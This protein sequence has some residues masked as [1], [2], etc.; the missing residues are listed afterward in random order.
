MSKFIIQLNRPETFTLN[1]AQ[2][3][4]FVLNLVQKQGPIGPEGPAGSGGGGSLTVQE[5]DGNPSGNAS[6]LIF[7]NGTVSIDGTT[8]TITGLQGAS[9][10]ETFETVSQNLKA[11]QS[12]NNYTDNRLTSIIYTVPSMGAIQKTFNYTGDKITS[13]VLAN[14]V[15]QA[16]PSGISLTKTI[17]YTGN[18][19]SGV[20]YS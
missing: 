9:W 14:A 11:Y 3:E 20:T 4:V 18:N 12:V 19:I 5:A 16:L 17:T 7:P 13:I 2:P 6:T 8:A 1:L 15:G 10:Q